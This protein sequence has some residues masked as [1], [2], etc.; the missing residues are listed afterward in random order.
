MI[1]PLEYC[2][3]LAHVRS[4]IDTIDYRILELIALRKDYVAKAAEFKNSTEE[5]IAE[6]R[7]NQMPK[8][9]LELAKGFGL[10]ASFVEGIFSDIVN[11][12]INEELNKFDEQQ[13]ISNR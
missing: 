5:V 7:V 9:R 12:F 4:S 6:E 13:S 2:E 3:N 11:Y 10:K 8:D 1:R